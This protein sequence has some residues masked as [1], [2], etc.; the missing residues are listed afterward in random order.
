MSEN[1]FKV[2][3]PVEELQKKKLF[4]ATPM[5]GGQCAGMFAKS[6]ADLS[7]VCTANGINLRSYFLFNESLITRARNYLVDEFL[8]SDCTHLMFIDSD[9]GFDPNDVIALS[10]IAA[11]GTDKH[12]VCGPYPKK[13]IAWEKIK[14]AVD[15]GFADK[16]PNNLDRYV[17]DTAP[18]G[19][20]N[21][22]N[23]ITRTLAIAEPADVLKVMFDANIPN[24]TTVMVYY[25]TWTG[26]DVNLNRLRWTDT[27]YISDAKD[28]G[29]DFV[30]REVTV[31]GIPSFNNAQIKIVFKST[32]PVSIPQLKNLRLLALS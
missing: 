3:V 26:N 4:V 14:R 5:Y 8:R 27:G 32:N 2:Q 17:G 21:Q 25:R 31:T 29:P 30:E 19:T 15:K 1:D 13:C 10:V 20:T 24:D 22:A 11:E 7:S 23:Y 9:I 28:V 16:D 12:I 6:V 18:Y